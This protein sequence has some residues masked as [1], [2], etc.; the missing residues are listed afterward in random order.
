MLKD[1]YIY[2]SADEDFMEK[3]PSNCVKTF[4]PYHIETED[5]FDSYDEALEIAE[6]I[7][8]EGYEAFLAREGQA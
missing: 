5:E 3:I 7:E 8:E 1:Q 4:Q 6:W 2:M